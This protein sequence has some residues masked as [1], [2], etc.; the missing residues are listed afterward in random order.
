MLGFWGLRVSLI[1]AALA[2]S[3]AAWAGDPYYIA[4]AQADLADILA[5]PPAQDSPEAKADLR[6]VLAAVKS[7]TEAAIKHAQADDHKIVFRFADVMGP[8]FTPEN[9]P[10][11]AQFFQHVYEDGN[12]IV[13]T[14]K[15]HF[16]RQRPFV[17]DPAIKIIV[18]QKPDYS[19]P[20]NHS[21]FAY[22]AAILLSLMVPEKRVALFERAADYGHNRVLAGVH[23]PTDIEGGRITGSVIDNVLLHDARFLADFERSKA[24]VRAALG[25]QAA[26]GR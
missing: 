10:F 7:R 3:T 5:P 13:D 9:L 23:F 16:Q 18:V 25:L 2:V 22:E 11:T 8:N 15:A 21:T 12:V 24:E 14:T 26:N 20:S 1:V 17:V 4:P 6:E 19:Y